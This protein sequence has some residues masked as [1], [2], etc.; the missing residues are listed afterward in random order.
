MIT[1]YLLIDKPKDITSMRCVQKIKK[2]IG[3]H[4]PANEKIKIGHAGTLDPFATGLL[5]I[6]IGKKAT[7]SIGQLV[8]LEKKYVVTAKLGELT[9]TLDCTGQ[10][11][12]TAEM[13]NITRD[14]IEKSIKK[15]GKTYKQKPPIYSA[16]KH[17]GKP[18]YKL[19]REKKLSIE[20]LEKIVE[21]KTRT[22]DLYEVKLIDYKYPFFKFFAHVSKGTYIRSLANDIAEIFESFAT[23]YELRRTH[24]G[25][26]SVENAIKLEKIR[27]FDAIEKNLLLKYN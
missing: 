2:I 12:K 16:L 11:L 4:I 22:V 7:K 17:Q 23:T 20:E 27:D 18:L 6:C 19:A 15:L 9:D 26:F 8:D 21:S 5:L 10:I 14:L 3:A 24:I 13:S 1:G 25:N